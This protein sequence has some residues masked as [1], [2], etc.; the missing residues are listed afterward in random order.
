M[1]IGIIRRLIGRE[2][3]RSAQSMHA[4]SSLAYLQISHPAW[5]S[6]PLFRSP[7]AFL[8]CNCFVKKVQRAV[9]GV[10]IDLSSFVLACAAT[11]VALFGCFGS[12]L[13]LLGNGLYQDLSKLVTGLTRN[14]DDAL[15]DARYDAE[16]PRAHLC[17]STSIAHQGLEV[18]R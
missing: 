1:A 4:S 13:H 12:Y 8:N 6:H 16:W 3:L 18:L 7:L 2:S 17:C 14:G 9:K 11:F 10:E 15:F 5:F